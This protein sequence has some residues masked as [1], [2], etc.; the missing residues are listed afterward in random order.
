VVAGAY[1][2][3]VQQCARPRP[4]SGCTQRRVDFALSIARPRE[5]TGEAK[6]LIITLAVSAIQSD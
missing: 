3:S 5:A 4:H 6:S 1:V 2:K